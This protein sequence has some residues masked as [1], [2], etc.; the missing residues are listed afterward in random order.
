VKAKVKKVLRELDLRRRKPGAKSWCIWDARQPGL[1]LRVRPSGHAAVAFVYNR[2]GKTRW[3]TIGDGVL[4]S[5]ARRI[6]AKLRLAVLEGKDPAAERIA[7]RESDT[8]A[9]LHGRY[10][11]EWA[12]RENKSWQQADYLVRK[13]LLPKWGRKAAKE[14]TR[15]DVKAAIGAIA[16]RSVQNQVKAA[17]SA[18]FTWAI[19][20]A[21]VLENNPCLGIKRNEMDSRER[22]LSDSEIALFWPHLSRPLRVLLL[23][24]QRP[25]EVGAMRR[26]HVKDGW[27]EMP[28]A[29]VPALGWPGTKNGQNH[30]VWLPH[31]A[32]EIV[33]EGGVGRVFA[34]V[35]LD[36]EM[37]M[38][39]TRLGVGE[40][41]T[42]HDLRRS[43]GTMI[44]KLEFGR[45][46]MNRIQNHVEGGITDV[47]D[48]HRYE[49]ENKRVMETVAEHILAIAE[50]RR[51]GGE[52]VRGLFSSKP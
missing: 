16:S 41:A 26:E 48:R 9:E 34:R 50:G 5:D 19:E 28:G 52:V 31:A 12:K 10:V 6:A 35:E 51:A 24:G 17:A 39:C 14:I 33:G 46:A 13:H 44:T 20:E 7:G 11:E 30:R 15:A 2:R 32:R 47:Y 43:H 38:I 8:F 29:P 27:W 4:L 22:V 1:V 49:V 21:E 3:Y 25:G 40:K 37:R 18:V 36:A 42:P 45:D 23:V